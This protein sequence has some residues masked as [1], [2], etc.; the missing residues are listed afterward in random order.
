LAL[1]WIIARVESLTQLRFDEKYVEKNFWPCA[2]CSL[3]RSSRGWWVSA[4]FPLRR[5]VFHKPKHM[6]LWSQ[7]SKQK[8][9]VVPVGE[10]IHWSVIERLGR[11]A[12]SGA[13]RTGQRSRRTSGLRRR[14][15]AKPI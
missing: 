9:L 10:K 2:A 6:K 14:R 8:K 13:R 7:G 3:Y 12:S 1:I 11:D 15:N 5:L 4:L